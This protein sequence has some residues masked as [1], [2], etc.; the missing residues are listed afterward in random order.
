MSDKQKKVLVCDDDPGILEVTKII[1]ETSGYRVETV[2][3]GRAIIKNVKLFR[4]DLILLDLWMPGIEGK[5]V[6]KLL[7][8]DPETKVIPLIIVSAINELEKEM[9]DI[10]ADEFIS[11]PFDMNELLDLVKKHLDRSLKSSL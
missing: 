1:L 2:N 3:T 9:T 4:P 5:E 7:K 11:K 10:L 8:R 6:T